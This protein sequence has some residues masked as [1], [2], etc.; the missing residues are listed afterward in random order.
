MPYRYRGDIA[1]ADAAF[2]AWGETLEELFRSAAEATLGVMIDDPA[3]VYPKESVRLRLAEQNTEMLLF[4]L[5]NQIIFYKDARRLLLFP[6]ELTIQETETCSRLRGTLVGEEIDP[7]RHRLDTDVKAVTMHR[8][9]LERVAEG[10]RA[11]V[12]LDV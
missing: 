11:T 4:E 9:A 12:V 8:F 5:L 10:W 2:D 7:S 6:G 3:S 1:H